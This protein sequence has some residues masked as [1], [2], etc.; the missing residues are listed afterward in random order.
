MTP[1]EQDRP[2]LRTT[3]PRQ[4]LT[5]GVPSSQGTAAGTAPPAAC[6]S[7]SAGDRGKSGAEG[8]PH[9]GRA[10]GASTRIHTASGPGKPGLGRLITETRR[11]AAQAQHSPAHF[12]DE[13]TEAQKSEVPQPRSRS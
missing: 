11:E 3:S 1:G 10:A 9:H 8:H 13:E 5:T 6:R 2:G 4:L 12:A 7:D